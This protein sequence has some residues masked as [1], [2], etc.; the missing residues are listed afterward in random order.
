MQPSGCM[1]LIIK[2]M[3]SNHA[4]HNLPNTDTTN[5]LGLA[6]INLQHS[7]VASANL[8]R[9]LANM[10]TKI[11]LIQEPYFFKEIR[12]L[13]NE[14]GFTYYLRNGCKSRACIYIRKD[15]NAMMLPQFCSNDMIVVQVNVRRIENHKIAL[16]FSLSSI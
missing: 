16:L 14:W 4:P 9:L 10:H 11:F 7:K 12:G 8:R 6:Q 3:E 2:R 13:D 15:V 5:G 1:A